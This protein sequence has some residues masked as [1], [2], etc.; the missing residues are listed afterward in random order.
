[1]PRTSC[2]SELYLGAFTRRHIGSAGYTGKA[3]L[4][5]LEPRYCDVAVTRWQEWTGVAATL[6]AVNVDTV[7]PRCGSSVTKTT[8]TAK[9]HGG[10][11]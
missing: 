2:D 10:G 5:E 7:T 4:I 1:M 8:T 11:S 6:S 9:S 3:G